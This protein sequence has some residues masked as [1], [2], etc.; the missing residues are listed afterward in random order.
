MHSKNDHVHFQPIK[1]ASVDTSR[2]SIIEESSNQNHSRQSQIALIINLFQQFTVTDF[3]VY[4]SIPAA[5]N[6]QA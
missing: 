5:D 1:Y 4:S 3:T 2:V 6:E